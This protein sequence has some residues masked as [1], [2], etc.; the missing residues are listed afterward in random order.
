MM[1][2]INTAYPLFSKDSLFP[3]WGSGRQ[4]VIAKELVVQE[5]GIHRRVA[6]GVVD[7]EVVVQKGMAQKIVVQ[8][9]V[10]SEVVFER[11]VELGA[12]YQRES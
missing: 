3:A 1:K 7:E 5:V 9:T 10:S 8:N 12:G 11:T 6:Q 4:K 2:Y